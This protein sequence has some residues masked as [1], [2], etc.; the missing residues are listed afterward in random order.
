MTLAGQ[1]G[2][3]SEIERSVRCYAFSRLK[4]MLQSGSQPACPCRN[5]VAKEHPPWLHALVRTKPRLFASRSEPADLIKVCLFAD[6]K[7]KQS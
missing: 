1:S 5:F 6:N 2:R 3:R 4:L 7:S